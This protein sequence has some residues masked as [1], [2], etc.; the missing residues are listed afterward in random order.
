MGLNS[1]PAEGNL[2]IMLSHLTLRMQTHTKQYAIRPVSL[3]SASRESN[4]L[5]EMMRFYLAFMHSHANG[6]F[7]LAYVKSFGVLKMA[8]KLHF[9]YSNYIYAP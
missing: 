4:K 7:S 9:L 2:S 5:R 8:I 1:H 3:L 6:D